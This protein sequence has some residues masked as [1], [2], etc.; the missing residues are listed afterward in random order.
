MEFFERIDGVLCTPLRR[1]SSISS[2]SWESHVRHF[3]ARLSIVE[4]YRLDPLLR[5]RWCLIQRDDDAEL[6]HRL[7]LFA[8]LL[9]TFLAFQSVVYFLACL[10]LIGS[11]YWWW[12]CFGCWLLG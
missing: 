1:G 4:E 12:C 6:L 11:S 7:A 9:R 2:G 3:L 8:H 10:G 5:F